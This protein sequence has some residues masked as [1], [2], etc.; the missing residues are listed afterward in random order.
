[1]CF[2][3][4]AKSPIL[5]DIEQTPNKSGVI[6]PAYV[7]AT[8]GYF[9]ISRDRYALLHLRGMQQSSVLL[10]WLPLAWSSTHTNSH[11]AAVFFLWLSTSSCGSQEDSAAFAPS[12]APCC[13]HSAPLC[14]TVPQKWHG[15]RGR[16]HRT[17]C[18]Q[19]RL[20]FGNNHKPCSREKLDA[21]CL[22]ALSGLVTASKMCV[23]IFLQTSSRCQHTR[24][25]FICDPY[26]GCSHYETEGNDSKAQRKQGYSLPPVYHLH[27]WGHDQS[28]PESGIW[29]GMLAALFH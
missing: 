1:M 12:A 7:K 13:C 23:C 8:R 25:F 19:P 29:S 21:H 14:P 4:N 26:C 2:K 9:K 28:Q 27:V 3:G 15:G 24:F 5:R 10:S 20:S 11:P 6:D 22:V 18:S 17:G 16:G